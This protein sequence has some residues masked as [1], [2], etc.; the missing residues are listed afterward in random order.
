M[1]KMC[2]CVLGRSLCHV[3]LICNDDDAKCDVRI[4]NQIK[5]EVKEEDATD[6]GY[7]QEN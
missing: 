2:V 6:V 4:Q 7:I 3:S 5:R 1:F